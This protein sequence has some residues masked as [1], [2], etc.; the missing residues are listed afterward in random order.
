[1]RGAQDLEAEQAWAG[2]QNRV[3]ELVVI[4][5]RRIMDIRQV[6]PYAQRR[7]RRQALQ[8]VVQE[9]CRVVCGGQAQRPQLGRIRQVVH[10][11]QSPAKERQPRECRA[12]EPEACRDVWTHSVET[13]RLERRVGLQEQGKGA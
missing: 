6:D 2:D 11:I 12:W 7:K 10:V 3:E 9:E 1:M 8:K 4:A 5:R 13:E